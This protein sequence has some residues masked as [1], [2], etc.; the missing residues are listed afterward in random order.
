MTFYEFLRYYFSF[1][2]KEHTEN[3]DEEEEVSVV[4]H[5]YY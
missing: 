1:F 2:I 4:E 3:D 5:S